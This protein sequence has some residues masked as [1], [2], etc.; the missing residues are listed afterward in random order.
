MKKYWII[1]L[2]LTSI[3][4]PAVLKAQYR[5]DT[6]YYD[7][8]W[9]VVPHK[10]FAD[11]YRIALYPT[12]PSAKKLLRD[13][14]I[15][16]ELQ[17][18]GGFI[19]IGETAG[20]TTIFDG[21]QTCYYKNGNKASEVT[22]INGKLNGD[23]IEYAENGLVTFKATLK[24]NQL[25]GLYTRFYENGNYMQAEYINGTPKYP[26]YI[27]GNADGQMMKIKFDDNSPYWES[28]HRNDRKT[29]YRQGTTWQYYVANGLCI[30]T[31]VTETKD[32]GKW[33]RVDLIITNDSPVP[34]TFDAENVKGNII[35][36]ADT[37]R[38]L[39]TWTCSEYMKRINNRQTWAAV[40]MGLAEGMAT[41]NAGYTNTA[42]YTST[43]YNGNAYN[44]GSYN[45]HS[46]YSG[47]ANTYSYS[48]SYDA[49]AAYQARVLSAQR[50]ADFS[51]AQW[52][53]KQAKNEGYIKRNTIN[54]GETI[55]GYVL[56][57]RKPSKQLFVIVDIYGAKYRYEWNTQH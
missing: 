18:E 4:I 35:T 52:Y 44:Y 8:N 20:S 43:Y 39:K 9:M 32:Y 28:P 45:G 51:E 2:L 54:P 1:F 11:F 37:V 49:A 41:A 46:T 36:Q 40:A 50:M 16:G 53:E 33:F 25:D 38:R 17:A 3:L 14:Y 21:L 5:I 13:Y 12:D 7:K 23:H 56:I 55:T 24:D 10:S 47:I 19:S 34:I 57:E 30:A 31:T 27:Y 26:Y 42:T 22:Y 48:T 29:I 6:I 15:T